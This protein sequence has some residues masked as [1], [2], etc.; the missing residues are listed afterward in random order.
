MPRATP[1]E[2]PDTPSSWLSPKFLPMVES[3][4]SPMN[5]IANPVPLDSMNTTPQKLNWLRLLYLFMVLTVVGL[6]GLSLTETA[7]IFPNWA[8]SAVKIKCVRESVKEELEE[9]I[10]ELE[11][12]ITNILCVSPASTVNI[13]ALPAELSG[14]VVM[15][16]TSRATP[17]CVKAVS[18]EGWLI[19]IKV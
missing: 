1:L 17:T 18:R 4:A 3:W 11:T 6:R 15:P 7:L 16:K 5:S 12:L 9:L 14:T 10:V 13:V 8:E 2:F 19:E